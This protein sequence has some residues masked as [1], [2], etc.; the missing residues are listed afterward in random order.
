MSKTF[1]S[2]QEMKTTYGLTDKELRNMRES[3]TVPVVKIGR[4]YQYE[5]TEELHKTFLPK[6]PDTTNLST[7]A[8]FQH[9]EKDFKNTEL[10]L[11]EYNTYS[12]I[13]NDKRLQQLTKLEER[14]NL[15]EIYRTIAEKPEVSNCIDEIINEILSP[16]ETGELVKLSF[17]DED[18]SV[19]EETK[20]AIKESYKK[21]MRLLDFSNTSDEIVRDWYRDGFVPFECI[22]NNEE[23]AKTG[24]KR[25]LQLSPFKFKRVK[26]VMDNS[27]F[28]TYD[29]VL[30]GLEIANKGS[31][32]GAKWL[33]EQVVVATSGKMDPS[34]TYDSSYLREA[35]KAI[36]DLAHIENSLVVYRITRASEKNVWNID[37]GNLP[38]QKAKNHLSAVAKDIN[39]NIKYNS[40]T[41]QTSSEVAVGVQS[42]WIFPSR[43]GKQKTEVSTID[44]N[45]DFISKLEDL[46]YFRKKVNEALKIP[47][48]RL[49]QQ[50]TLDFS[51]EDILREELKFTLFVNKLRRRIGQSLFLPLIYR[52]L[53]AMGK[54]KEE[55]WENVKQKIIFK[56]NNSNAIVEKA[57]ANNL[58]TKL[59]SLAEVE[60]SGVVGKHV[61]IS[62]ILE[63]ILQMSPEEYKEQKEKIQKE[64]EEGLYDVHSDEE[65]STPPSRF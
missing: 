36:N 38:T 26:D 40:E 60:D 34:K 8:D 33:E 57:K 55:E 24:I 43:N 59:E 22:Y 1:Y 46:Q 32:T 63:N 19:G 7:T 58:K 3:S 25:I 44:G 42:N 30:N 16:F 53:F 39:T 37:V 13:Y 62:Y 12:G 56:W 15:I 51:S 4:G 49:D 27:Y 52:D 6:T 10:T 20:Y 31:I 17:T 28:Y 41:G 65:E 2:S 48:G 21:I 61:S 9:L 23:K 14:D 47:V 45:A 64:R 35:M 50:S 54:I 29:T 18:K 11:P 5:I